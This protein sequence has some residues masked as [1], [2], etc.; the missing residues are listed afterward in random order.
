MTIDLTYIQ[1]V[2]AGD[3]N[4]YNELMELMIQEMETTWPDFV[5]YRDTTDYVSMDRV[6][7]TLKNKLSMLKLDDE[8]EEMENIRLRLKKQNLCED[9]EK[10][11]ESTVNQ[12][13]TEL[14][15]VFP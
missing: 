7:H 10:Y 9:D 1:E 12:I 14:R 5:K 6:V 13:L 4:L 11:I 2:A 15:K 8:I 3:Q